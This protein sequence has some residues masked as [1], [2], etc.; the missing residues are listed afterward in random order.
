MMKIYFDKDNKWCL[1]MEDD[2]DERK[3]YWIA[4]PPTDGDRTDIIT[5]EKISEYHYNFKGIIIRIRKGI[6]TAELI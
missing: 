5:N 1:T 3:K 6:P 4:I 2:N